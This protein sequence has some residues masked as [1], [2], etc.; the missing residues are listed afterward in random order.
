MKNVFLLPTDKPSRLLFDKEEDRLLPLHYEPVFMEHQD[1]VENQHIY[2]TSNEEIKKDEFY[3]GDDNH[4]Y[5]LCTT[6]NSNGK[7][8]ILTTNEELIEEGIQAID[9]EFLEWFINNPSCEEIGVNDWLDDNGNIAFGNKER[10][11]IVI[12]K[13]EPKQEKIEEVLKKI[14]SIKLLQ[15]FLV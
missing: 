12:P 8:I 1:L 4:I 15:F 14:N 5:N 13:E 6:V 9:D 2:I 7:K 3:L 11:K 10:Y